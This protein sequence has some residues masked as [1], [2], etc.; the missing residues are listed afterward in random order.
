MHR[1]QLTIVVAA[2]FLL[3]AFQAESRDR[4][5]YMADLSGDQQV[6]PVESE[7]WG[8]FKMWAEG[9]ASTA[10]FWVK[11]K[12]GTRLTQAH[13][14]CAAEGSNGPVVAFLAGFHELGWDVNGKW[15]KAF[16]TDENILANEEVSDECPHV[17]VTLA[18]LMAAMD[19]GDAYVNVHSIANP[20]G[21]LRGQ[22]E[23]KGQPNEPPSE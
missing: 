20:G 19:A 10:K 17:I 8:K 14:H 21:E 18:D 13:I 22:I 15:S 23:L 5:V 7:A 1:I 2:A 6:E 3:F 12:N 16:I 9:D 4:L 11:V